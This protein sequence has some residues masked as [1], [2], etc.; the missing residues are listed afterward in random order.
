MDWVL[1]SPILMKMAGPTSM[2]PMIIQ[3]LII[4]TS[5][6]RTELLPINWKKAI[7]HTSQFSMGNDV[8]DINNDGASGYFYT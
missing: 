6:I 2:Y 8:A 1:V 5:I 4:S 3:F 7:G